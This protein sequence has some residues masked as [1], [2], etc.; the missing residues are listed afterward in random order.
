MS[1]VALTLQLD[2]HPVQVTADA[3]MYWAEG[4]TLIVA[5]VHFGK[6][7]TFRQA[8]RWVP[9]GTTTSDLERM[10]QLIAH[11]R[12]E[13][14]VILGDAFHSEHAVEPATL[15]TLAQWRSVTPLEVLVIRGNHDRKADALALELDFAL[16]DPGYQLGPWHLYHHPTKSTSGYVLCG[17][18]HP[19]VYVRG[20]ARQGLRVP[21]FWAS[22]RQCVLPAFGGF[23]GGSLIRPRPGDQVVLIAKG[24]VVAM[25]TSQREKS[26]SAA[27]GTRRRA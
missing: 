27:S 2:G 8:N 15:Q 1:D 6:D 19:Q 9:P 17:H 16:L 5:D 18:L 24:R 25:T 13:R 7:A 11:W 22:T 20:A 4:K 14:L 26:L 3:A 21:C 12:P 10:S 23:T